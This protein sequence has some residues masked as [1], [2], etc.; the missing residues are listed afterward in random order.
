[1]TVADENGST[2]GS[3][4]LYIHDEL[5]IMGYTGTVSYVSVSENSAVYSG[6]TLL[7][8]SGGGK[9]GL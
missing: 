9:R 2:L 6:S 3:G 7:S 1:M 4:A 5:K 8:L